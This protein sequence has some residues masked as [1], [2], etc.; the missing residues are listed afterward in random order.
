[1]ARY[2]EQNKLG[3]V[4][5]VLVRVEAEDHSP[6][7]VVIACWQTSYGDIEKIWH[8]YSHVWMVW[9]FRIEGVM[10]LVCGW[11]ALHF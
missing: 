3:A 8:G 2:A 4:K 10:S 1:M 5:Y 7:V 9:V 6:L 11:V